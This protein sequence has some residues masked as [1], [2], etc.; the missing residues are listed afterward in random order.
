MGKYLWENLVITFNNDTKEFKNYIIWNNHL[1][2]E[3][4]KLLKFT[5]EKIINIINLDTLE[6]RD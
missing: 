1:D 6:G 2:N 4:E 5:N 3:I